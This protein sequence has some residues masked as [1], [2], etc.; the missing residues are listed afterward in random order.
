MY[1]CAGRLEEGRVESAI[2]EGFPECVKVFGNNI[3]TSTALTKTANFSAI[4]CV[5]V[6]QIAMVESQ[7]GRVM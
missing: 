6:T 1:I 4:S 7:L 3:S 2:L 5:G